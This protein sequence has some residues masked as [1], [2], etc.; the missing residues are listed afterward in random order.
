MSASLVSDSLT[1]DNHGSWSTLLVW[2]FSSHLNGCSFI[3]N[4]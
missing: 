3:L 1:P 4:T 2:L